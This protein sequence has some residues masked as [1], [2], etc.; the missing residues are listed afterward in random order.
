MG[1]NMGQL[2]THILTHNRLSHSGQNSISQI[3]MTENSEKTQKFQTYKYISGLLFM[4]PGSTFCVY[5]MGSS[6]SK[7]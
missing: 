4:M 3:A 7:Y 2:L 5:I 6:L 1:Q